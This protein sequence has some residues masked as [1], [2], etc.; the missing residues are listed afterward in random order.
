M[1]SETG[2]TEAGF[3]ICGH[4]S[5]DQAAMT[6]FSRLVRGLIERLPARAVEHGSLEFVQPTIRDGLSALRAKGYQRIVVVPAM[7]FGST[8]VKA[9]IPAILATHRARYPEI[10]LV[11]APDL[12]C[13]ARLIA[14]AAERIGAAA[15]DSD[16]TD[17]HIKLAN[18]ALLL[19]GRGGS[20]A[21]A[22]AESARAAR[23]LCEQL[24]LAHAEAAFAGSAHP[25]V[26]D[27]LKRLVGQG[28]ARIVVF[29]FLLVPGILAQRVKQAV[30]DAA[31]QFRNIQFALAGTLAR[32]PLVLDAL[33]TLAR[34]ATNQF[35]KTATAGGAQRRDQIEIFGLDAMPPGWR[36]ANRHAAAKAETA[37][38]AGE[39]LS[40]TVDSGDTSWL[41]AGGLTLDSG[42]AV[43][44]TVSYRS[45]ILGSD[46]LVLHP[47]VL[48]LGLDCGRET[49][50]NSLLSLVD[51]ALK[52]NGLARASVAVIVAP[53]DRAD[54][55]G[56]HALGAKFDIP[57]RFFGR[58]DG[59][60]RR[61]D[62]IFAEWAAREAVGFDAT[63]VARHYNTVEAT[64]AIAL[65]PEINAATI[66][67]P[68][69]RVTIVGAGSGDAGSQTP[70]SIKTLTRARHLVG[71]GPN[72]DILGT[73]SSTHT[74]HEY[75]LGEEIRACRKAVDLAAR[76]QE[77]ALITA[78]E[79]GFNTMSAMVWD[80][81]AEADGPPARITVELIPAIS[82]M[83]TAAAATGAPLAQD[84]CVI[85]LT[86]PSVA[87][88]RTVGRLTA[89]AQ[90]DFVV[91]LTRIVD[92][93]H[94]NA[95]NQAK[96]ILLSQR[97]PE[98]PVIVS[99][100][101]GGAHAKPEVIR[102]GDLAN[103]HIGPQT[104][105]IIG[106][107]DSRSIFF[108]GAARVYAP[109]GYGSIPTRNLVA[110]DMTE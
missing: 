3:L 25:S 44:I 64:C 29:P 94:K 10:E 97:S 91:V 45:Q 84:F 13:D 2:N 61:E 89:A 42:A 28:F 6:E 22:N 103:S 68:R 108:A 95:L 11:Q 55:A 15:T 1:N 90:A 47:P 63:L 9:D 67:R 54:T 56:L 19:V 36:A 102:L 49:S 58:T 71:Y 73:G 87:W 38:V 26:A 74:R 14:A 106:A 40:L 27:A 20:N 69:G 76:G 66:G 96:E 107:S 104:M 46:R 5:R 105:L 8:H 50:L 35:A 57:V 100:P 101:N 110:R 7:L 65:G 77:V 83:Q 59:G 51:D 92:R 52:Q 31:G 79:A 16:T 75:P 23:L 4:G 78:G 86:D 93:K 30:T 41:S 34:E 12:S 80:L 99:Q 98:T 48:A 37:L 88:D 72:L 43:G 85:A 62:G 17:G 53:D 82:Q 81:I 39:P 60:E 32:H 18:T 33:E 109:R 21:D 70:T 24:G